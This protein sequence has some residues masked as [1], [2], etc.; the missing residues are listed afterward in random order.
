MRCCKVCGEPGHISRGGEC[1]YSHQAL[2]YMQS[3]GC[4]MM[5]AAEK[6]GISWQSMSEYSQR[7]ATR[8][9]GR[10]IDEHW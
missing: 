8:P 10:L 7:Q 9:L 6:Y 5:A 1:S 2:S 3:T 4:T